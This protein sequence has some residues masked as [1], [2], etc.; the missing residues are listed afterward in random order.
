MKALVVSPFVPYPPRDGG[1][2][3]MHALLSRLA[4][5]HDVE[6]LTLAGP[7]E[8]H[9]A[10]DSLEDIGI[11]VAT[12][13]HSPNRIRAMGGA[14]AS[15]T[16][17]YAQLYRSKA[18]EA[19]VADRVGR[20]AVDV[21]Q[22]EFSLLGG[23]VPARPRSGPPWIVAA[24]NLEFRLAGAAPGRGVVNRLY[25]RREAGKRR[26]EELGAFRRADHVVA[27]SEVD[28]ASIRRF[29]PEASVSVVPNGVD[30]DAHRPSGRAEASRD[31]S[32]VFVGKMDFR[33]NV[34]AAQWFCHA[35]LPRVRE[36]RPDF[37]FTVCGGP[38]A[39]SVQRLGDDPSVRITG[40][41]AETDT[42]V[43][44]AA[45]VVVPLRAGSGTRLKI[46]EAFALG[47]PV[48]STTI[49]CEGLDVEPGR[50]LLVADGA[51]EMGD[52]IVE[53]LADPQ[54]RRALGEAGRQLAE[55]RY[56]WA[57]SAEGLES[58]WA[59]AAERQE[60]AA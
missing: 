42:H 36:A 21:V 31:P 47:R 18:L 29:V 30:V 28:A 33:P 49:G 60:V 48:V 43:D 56:D 55:E 52:A 3:R 59:N 11:R 17:L 51:A 39:S 5:R 50:H 23:Y 22:C 2:I 54:R 12:V 7:D 32:A 15:R 53:L 19:A 20:G 46:L 1:R 58:A 13:P 38:V 37:R 45:V 16:S 24:H 6:L 10:V 25:A 27:V 34:D 41:V 14:I 9:A 8:T 40:T 4:A 57:R 26:T 44:D 35:I